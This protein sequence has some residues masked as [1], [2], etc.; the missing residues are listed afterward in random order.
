MADLPLHGGELNA[1]A[2]LWRIPRENWLDLSTGINPQ[3]WPVPQIPEDVW[4]RLPE[5]DD[6]LVSAIRSWAQPHEHAG[7]LAVAGSQAA[8]QALPRLRAPGRVAVPRPGYEEHGHCWRA[9]G[10]EVQALSAE[11]IEAQLDGLDVVVWIQ[12]N[13]PTGELL[14]SERLLAWRNRL[15]QRDGWLI[16]DEAFISGNEAHSLA[17]AAGQPGLIV[18]RS[19]GKF[20]GLAGVRAGAVIACPELCKALGRLLGPWSVSGP[21]RYLME[22]ALAD[23]GWQQT[24]RRQLAHDSRCMA[25]LLAAHGLAPSGSTNLFCYVRHPNAFEIYQAL[26]GQAVLVRHFTDPSGLRIGLPGSERE[27]A[28]LDDALGRS[29]RSRNAQSD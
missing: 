29:S 20:F 9:S 7:V 17:A 14:A 15:A 2:A 3:A 18:L 1:A 6:A 4:R 22:R 8:I 11:A 27:W 24:T 25:E 12:P 19:L 23:F 13:N 28:R 5:D 21:A 16:V 10:H 26:A